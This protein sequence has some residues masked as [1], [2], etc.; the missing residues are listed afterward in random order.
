MS[1]HSFAHLLAPGRIGRLELRNR[2]LMCPMG[3]HLS[4]P[5]GSVSANE[6]AYFEARARGGAALLLVGNVG[7]ASPA[8]TSDGRMTAA[9]DDGRHLPGLTDL[10]QRVHRHGALI[11][12]QLNHQGRIALLDV[13]DGRPVLVPYVPEPPPPDPLMGMV[14]AAESAGMMAA[15]TRPGAKFEYRVATENDLAWVIARYVE[16]ADRC[17]RAGFDGVELHAGHGYLIDE[18]LSPANT[19]DDGW[20]GSLEGRARL[21]LEVI[22]AVRKRVGR[23]FP[24]WIRINALEPHKP[25]GERWDTQLQV[26]ELAVAAG[27]DAVHVTAYADDSTGPTDSYAPHVVGALADYS[28]E[29]KARVSVPLITFGRFEPD[30]ADRVIADGKADF[31]SMGRKLLADPDLPNKLAAGRVD[32]VRPCIYQYRCIGNIYVSEPLRCVA[33]AATGREHDAVLTPTASPRRVLV[34]GG[35]AAGLETARVLAERGHRVWLWEASDSL[36]GVLRHA[37]CA[38]PVLDRYL[39]WLVHT[40]EHS[41]VEIELGRTVD[42]DSAAALAPDE[43]VVATGAVWTRPRIPGFDEDHVFTVPDLEEWLL[44]YH[45]TLVGHHVVVVGG[46]KAGLSLADLCRRRGHDVA[47]IEPSNVFGTELG[48]P[49]RFR[50]VHDLEQAGV[51]LLSGTTVES[52]GSRA[53]HV[54]RGDA[55]D[56]VRAD[57]VIIASGEV[58]DTRLAVALRSAGVPVRTIGDCREVRHLEGANRDALDAAL[59][60]G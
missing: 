3:H 5:D 26:I 50:L 42:P 56:D 36:G 31:V 17:V 45:E 18:F 48:L 52:I 54:R 10:A 7:I 59:A 30:E 55:P 33:N 40:V 1:D 53:V 6:A 19:R 37:A 20:G 27:I 24:V 11:A 25:N 29:A 28:A 4:N 34:A 16:A 15:F 38:D 12:A 22:G 8:G 21:L 43:I 41:D 49:G 58:P 9:S 39:G 32:D 51:Q 47:L 44:G 13:A 14:T 57:T 60:I 35:G 2:I 23:D 46:G